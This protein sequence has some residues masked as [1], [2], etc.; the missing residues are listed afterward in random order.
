M[1]R[2][3]RPSRPFAW[4]RYTRPAAL[5]G[6]GLS[7]LLAW[8]LGVATL[9]RS[10]LESPALWELRQQTAIWL[11]LYVQGAYANL[12]VASWLLTGALLMAVVVLASGETKRVA[13]KRL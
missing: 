2:L 7:L 10:G 13:P 1:R 9:L 3:E 4:K 5:L 6:A 12:L 11:E 8:L